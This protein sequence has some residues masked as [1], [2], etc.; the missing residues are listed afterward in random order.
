MTWMVLDGI[1]I[2]IV[3]FC[4]ASYY[5]RGFL[6]ALVGIVSMAVALILALWLG[7]KCAQPVYDGIVRDRLVSAVES[8]LETQAGGAVDS[9]LE[10]LG[11]LV[12]ITK[13]DAAQAGNET[14]QNIVDTMLQD[15]AMTAIKLVLTLLFFAILYALL[16]GLEKKLRN[17]NEIPILGFANKLCGGALG[18]A[19]AAFYGFIYISLI[20]LIIN[21]TFDQLTWL[22]TD[23]IS[24]TWLLQLV[25]P[26]NLFALVG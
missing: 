6:S 10:G 16:R 22:N 25:Y 7:G 19:V 23:V 26:Y 20:A 12:G 2:L 1:L 4:V 17:M 24:R 21:M 18:I 9:L 3:L 8:K 15:K 11:T 14:A 5:R 13:E